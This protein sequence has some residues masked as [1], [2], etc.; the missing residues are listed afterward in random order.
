[1]PP[2][3]S[4]PPAQLNPPN[5]SV[6]ASGDTTGATDVAAIQ[7]AINALFTAGG[8]VISMVGAFNIN[9]GIQVKGGIGLELRKANIRVVNGANLDYVFA[10]PAALSTGAGKTFDAPIQ[11]YNGRI[12]GNMA[13]QTAGNAVGILLGSGG[14][15]NGR[16]T[17]VVGNT[18]V[19]MRGE[20]GICLTELNFDGT[21]L[22]L[23]GSVT[24]AV[25]PLIL[26]N[27]VLN[28]RGVGIWVKHAAGNFMTD[29]KC[30]DNYVG[31]AQHDGIRIDSFGGWYCVSN[32][33]YAVG[34]SGILTQFNYAS[35]LLN[36]YVEGFGALDTAA[37][38]VGLAA[39]AYAAGTT[40]ALNQVVTYSSTVYI[41]RVDGN[42][43]NQPDVS[44]TQWRSYVTGGNSVVG[45]GSFNC[46]S[47]RSTT[48]KDNK[49]SIGHSGTYGL[50][51]SWQYRTLFCQGPQTGAGTHTLDWDYNDVTNEYQGAGTN[52]TAFRLSTSSGA[53]TGGLRV[54][55]GN[56]NS[57]R[58]AF[59]L[60]YSVDAACGP[61]VTAGTAAGTTGTAVSLSN[62]SSDER[63]TITVT[64]GSAAVTTGVLA[65]WNWSHSIAQAPIPL[66]T[67]GNA[68]AAT[69]LQTAGV[70][71]NP[72]TNG[73]SINVGVAPAAST[74][75]IFHLTK[76]GT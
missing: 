20:A 32:H 51:A 36:N 17:Q 2:L 67:A 5:T 52:T 10:S 33:V 25:E 46:V 42:V 4:I 6:V 57:A 69:L 65:T 1:M 56:F 27:E 34:L 3:L 64:T 28:V 39:P 12:D 11:I 49:I 18:V 41:S 22:A 66:I 50:Q 71:L 38:S 40:Y 72:G 35:W 74:T 7:A 62:N 21:A 44:P 13:N 29:G 24:T 61:T 19:N 54:I 16:R 30:Q 53:G 37:S 47:G 60:F 55:G 9:A 76:S 15:A 75:Y 73:C 63:A 58:G 14:D 68:A 43:G 31:F 23:S 48:M 59:N 45:I 8:G 26:N 70:F